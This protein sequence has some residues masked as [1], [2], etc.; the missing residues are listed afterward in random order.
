MRYPPGLDVRYIL[1]AI[2]L[3]GVILW[4]VGPNLGILISSFVFLDLIIA[5]VAIVRGMKSGRHGLAAGGCICGL[6]ALS[7]TQYL[8]NPTVGVFLLQLLGGAVGLGSF[9]IY[10]AGRSLD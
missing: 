1:G 9:I 7:S 2:V 8:E 3:I 5:F 4:S 10:G 6:M